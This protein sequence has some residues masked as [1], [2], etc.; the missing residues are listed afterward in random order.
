MQ[1]GRELRTLSASLSVNQLAHVCLL[2][3]ACSCA[4]RSSGHMTSTFNTWQN[5]APHFTR[6][7]F[8][9]LYSYHDDSLFSLRVDDCRVNSTIIKI[10]TRN[11]CFYKNNCPVQCD[12]R[13]LCIALHCSKSGA[14]L[15]SFVS[16]LG[17]L[18]CNDL[19]NINRE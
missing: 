17:S 14:R 6:Q 11:V 19:I 12:A 2:Q 18:L 7:N 15:N 8:A 3:T 9:T 5:I 1:T 16:F 4:P 13:C 10:S